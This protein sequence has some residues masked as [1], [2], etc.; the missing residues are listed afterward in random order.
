VPTAFR[1]SHL[2][3]PPEQLM[4]GAPLCVPDFSCDGVHP[5]AR[6]Q[7]LAS[8]DSRAA[9]AAAT[10]AEQQPLPPRLR[11]LPAPKPRANR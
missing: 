11:T 9:A 10:A 7:H 6:C 5:A 3:V 8:V 4:H 2:L 1:A